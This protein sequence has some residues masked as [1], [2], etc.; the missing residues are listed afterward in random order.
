MELLMFTLLSLGCANSKLVKSPEPASDL[1]YITKVQETH[2]P[3]TGFNITQYKLR[4]P[5]FLKKIRDS[6]DEDE[7]ILLLSYTS[8]LYEGSKGY[9]IGVV[10]SL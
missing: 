1:G 7:Q 4:I 2:N 6:K 8:G 5:D 9:S 10:K 3:E